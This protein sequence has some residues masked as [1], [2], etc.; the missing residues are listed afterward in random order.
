MLYER[1]GHIRENVTPDSSTE[2]TYLFDLLVQNNFRLIKMDVGI[3]Y[4]EG[5]A[6]G[7]KA[8]A[9]V[10]SAVTYTEP[11]YSPHQHCR[12]LSI[13]SSNNLHSAEQ[14]RK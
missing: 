6:E 9:E 5:P 11:L 7:L 13:S 4:F 3:L 2:L 10:G 14:V 12:R 1:Q 8:R